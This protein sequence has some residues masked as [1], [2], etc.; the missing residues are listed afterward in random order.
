ME[1]SS[2]SLIEPVPGIER[3]QLDLGSFGQ[4]GGLVD[5]KSPGLHSSLQRHSTT[6]APRPLL[7]KG[8]AHRRMGSRPDRAA[9]INVDMRHYLD[10][11]T[12]ELPDR[13]PNPVPRRSSLPL[14]EQSCQSTGPRSAAVRTTPGIAVIQ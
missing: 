12:G 6:V 5:D 11:E 4:I 7:H 8:L 14:I 2:I 3:Q 13:L 1:R 10:E 9:R